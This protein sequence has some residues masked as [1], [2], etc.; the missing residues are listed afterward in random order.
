[1]LRHSEARSGGGAAVAEGV[2]DVVLVDAGHGSDDAVGADAAHAPVGG[3]GDVKA[4]F[5]VRPDVGWLAELAA[6]AGA[7]SPA[8]P[9]SFDPGIVLMPPLRPAR[10]MLVVAGVALAAAIVVAVLVAG[11]SRRHPEAVAPKPAPL[12]L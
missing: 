10:R 4:P 7:P 3:V 12:E 9:A 8:K 1:M 2:E 11:G 6:V 5:G